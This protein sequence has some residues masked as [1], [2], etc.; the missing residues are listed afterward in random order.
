M[1]KYN[2]LILCVHPLWNVIYDNNNTIEEIKK[3]LKTDAGRIQLKAQI[4]TYINTI[5]NRLRKNP[6]A[7]T[8]IIF[9]NKIAANELKSMGNPKYTELYW[10]VLEKQFRKKIKEL[11]NI[12]ISN[13]HPNKKR[14]PFLDIK[15]RPTDFERNIK[16]TAFGEQLRTNKASTK[17][18]GCVTQWF[19]ELK[20]ELKNNHSKEISH[21][22]LENATLDSQQSFKDKI[23]KL[24]LIK[25]KKPTRHLF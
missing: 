3:Y 2:E 22:I 25:N 15:V 4:T 17:M 20:I 23:Q 8:V 5:K 16:I 7:Y 21:T 9:P 10:E 6:R 13:W 1:V 24:N 12:E 19:N 11:K 14:D 18:N